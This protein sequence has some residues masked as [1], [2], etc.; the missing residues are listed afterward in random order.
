[1]APASS[2][3]SMLILPLHRRPTLATA[4]WATLALV[5]ANL[6]VFAFLQSGD[7]VA[8]E[9]ATSYYRSSGL[10]AVELPL[11]AEHLRARGEVE[12]ADAIA[13][14]EEPL[15]SR[16]A[17]QLLARDAA[18]GERIARDELLPAS[19]P[20]HAR[21]K[22]SR[23]RFDEML[24]AQ[25]TERHLLHYDGTRPAQLFTSMFLHADF[26]HLFGNMLFLVLLG[27][28]TEGALGSGLFVGLYL[29][30]GL[31][32]GALSLLRHLGEPGGALGASGAI[33]GLMGAF[34]VLWGL[35][36]VRVFYW[37]LFLF[38]YAKVPALL[39]LPVWLGWELY[40]LWFGPDIGVG[41]DAHA[42]G[43]ASGALLAFAVRR[44]GWE[45]D[46]FLDVDDRN[47]RLQDL[48]TESR[49]ALGRL[50]F[51]RART[52][53]EELRKLQPEDRELKRMR[54]RAWREQPASDTFHAAARELLLDPHGAGNRAPE[55]VALFDDYVAATQRK[56]RLTPAELHQI[57]RRWI[58]AGQAEAAERLLDAL[59][60]RQ[61]TLEG[62]AQSWLE[63]LLARR[64]RGDHSASGR[65]A[66]AIA[67]HF[68]ESPQAAKARL[69][70]QA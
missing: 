29:L 36:K 59:A 46:A 9:R 64:E 35:R 28:L 32:G 65:I 44:M 49:A 27:L 15:R 7:G 10:A 56:P 58:A 16:I 2:G 30:A 31:G 4:P 20:E 12:L 41:F 14:T 26:G 47:D 51:A 22:D 17:V 42:G 63:L 18:F 68:P 24:D 50:E 3:E 21:W 55:Q 70:A 33:A 25:F 69:L 62:L 23:L 60:R 6:F 57:V 37:F 38:D 66:T 67:R 53:I 52:L 11:Y 19:D 39:L 8:F 48:Q 1:M 54:F 43:I 5:L 61:P 45:R 34:C 40:N 13:Q